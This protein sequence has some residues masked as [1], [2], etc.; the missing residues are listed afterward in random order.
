QKAVDGIK[1]ELL[2]RFG[3]IPLETQM[4]LNITNLRLLAQKIGIERISEDIKYLYIYFFKTLD[5]SNL[6]ITRLINDYSNKIEFVSGKHYAFKL[7]KDTYNVNI[8]EYI[9]NFLVDLESNIFSA[10]K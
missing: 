3:K 7:I 4:L 6:D 2:D 5:F 1:L 10:K 9:K 8:V